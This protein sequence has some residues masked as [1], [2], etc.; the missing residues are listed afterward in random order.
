MQLALNMV[1]AKKIAL[2]A[3]PGKILHQEIE[4]EKGSSDLCY[5]FDIKRGNIVRE[6]GVDAMT[7]KVFKNDMD[8]D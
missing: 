4:H 3:F 5:S 8:S 2:K 1:Q 6:V 7:G